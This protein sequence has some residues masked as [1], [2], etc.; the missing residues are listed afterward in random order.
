MYIIYPHA[1]KQVFRR[2]FYEKRCLCYDGPSLLSFV[3]SMVKELRKQS[4]I[5]TTSMPL[6]SKSQ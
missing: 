4:E 3:Q 2:V 1:R 6:L 5:L